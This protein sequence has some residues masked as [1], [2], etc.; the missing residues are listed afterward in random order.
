MRTWA[1]ELESHTHDYVRRGGKQNRQ[2]QVSLIINF[3]EF[4]DTQE[5]LT[6]LQRLGKRHVINFWKA[7][8]HLPEKSAYDY[9]LGLC[10]LWS[11]LGKSE[12]PPRPHNHLNAI[13]CSEQ[14]NEDLKIF[15][16]L[17]QAIKAARKARGI[18]IQKLA[19]MTG[20]E[21]SVID[22]I[23]SGHFSVSFLEVQN[24]LVA[25]GIRYGVSQH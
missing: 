16:S 17:S 4:I 6:S 22:A 7:H 12:K 11:W 1:K 14:K 15:D 9:W 10:Q 8:R 25:L 21:V 18:P 2:K 24:L 3:L 19:N 5:G 13:A 23:E 20:C